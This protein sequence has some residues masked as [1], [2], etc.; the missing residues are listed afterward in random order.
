MGERPTPEG[1]RRDRL[2]EVASRLEQHYQSL[3]SD[4]FVARKTMH[5]GSVGEEVIHLDSPDNETTVFLRRVPDSNFPRDE[6]AD[7]HLRALPLGVISPLYTII[8]PYNTQ[9]ALTTVK[10]ILRPYVVDARNRAFIVSNYWIVSSAAEGFVYQDILAIPESDGIGDAAIDSWV[11]DS[12][13]NAMHRSDIELSEEDSRLVEMDGRTV[14]YL[15]Y[16]TRHELP[17][18]TVRL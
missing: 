12:E 2:L 6:T 10:G 13:N 4:S 1:L 15:T 5:Q 11:G 8:A 3:K 14:E 16:F 9:I 17:R 18:Y 7:V